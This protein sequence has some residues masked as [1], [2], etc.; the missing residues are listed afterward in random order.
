MS[1]HAESSLRVTVMICIPLG[2][3]NTQAHKQLLTGY[4]ISAA[5]LAKTVFQHVNATIVNCQ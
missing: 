5:S 4:T 1:V 2:S 3:I